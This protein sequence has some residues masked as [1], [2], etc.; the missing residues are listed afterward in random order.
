MV[1]NFA[2]HISVQLRLNKINIKTKTSNNFL[3]VFV[4]LIYDSVQLYSHTLTQ[5]VQATFEFILFP[6]HPGAKEVLPPL[7]DT[8]L[9]E[10]CLPSPIIFSAQV[11]AQGGW[12][13]LHSR[14]LGTTQLNF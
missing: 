4:S 13:S 6:D 11:Q 3:L 12:L 9:Q 14:L 5:K 2:F 10:C 1:L 7:L 8:V